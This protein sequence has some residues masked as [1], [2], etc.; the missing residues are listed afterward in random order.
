MKRLMFL[1]LLT[2]GFYLLGSGC[3]TLHARAGLGVFSIGVEADL[4]EVLKGTDVD[5]EYDFRK[6]PDE[7]NKPIIKGDISDSNPNKV[8][9]EVRELTTLHERGDNQ[10]MRG[11]RRNNQAPFTRIFR[12]QLQPPRLRV[13]VRG[14]GRGEACKRQNAT[15]VYDPGLQEAPL[16]SALE[17][18][19]LVRSLLLGRTDSGAQILL[20]WKTTMA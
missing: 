18:S 17:V 4:P 19:P 11:E 16:V 10:W 15:G 6:G 8:P 2:M 12:D 9:S 3:I 20:L 1:V 7:C 5:V 14:D 13:L